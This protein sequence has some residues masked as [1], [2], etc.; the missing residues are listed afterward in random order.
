MG[1]L[2]Y[3]NITNLQQQM[4][5]FTEKNVQEQL[6]VNQL[7]YE[8]ARL[9]NLE[10]AYLITGN[11]SYSTSYNMKIDAINKKNWRFTRKICRS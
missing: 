5:D 4:K 6:T 8:I 3:V 7:A 11:G 9:T 2:S 10:Q 1:I